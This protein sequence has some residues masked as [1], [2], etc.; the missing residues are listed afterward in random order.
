MKTIQVKPRISHAS[1]KGKAFFIPFNPKINHGCP[2]DHTPPI[3]ST[4]RGCETSTLRDAFIDIINGA[5]H[6]L[7][8]C[9]FLLGGDAVT[10]SLVEAARRLHGHTYVITAL[11][12]KGLRDGID[13][14]GEYDPETVLRGIKRFSALTKAGVYVRGAPDCHAKFLIADNNMALVTSSNFDQNGLGEDK[15][16]AAG[17]AGIIIRGSRALPL[18]EL[19][20][21]VWR[22][23]CSF[24][25]FPH[26][27]PDE[28][29]VTTRKSLTK[30]PPQ[31]PDNPGSVIWTADSCQTI[32]EDLAKHIEHAKQRIFLASYSFTSMQEN[33]KLL[34]E[35]LI[36]AANRGVKIELFLRV[37]T[38]DLSDLSPLLQVGVQVRG[39]LE[40]HAKYVIVD[41][42]F[43]A[44]FTA[45]FDGKHGLT[46]GVEVG[47]RLAKDEFQPLTNY[48][49]KC[50]AAATH[51]VI[52]VNN[53]DQLIKK[54]K[55]VF[56]Y[57]KGQLTVKSDYEDR[58][59]KIM[60]GPWSVVNEGDCQWIC[61]EKD[62]IIIDGSPEKKLTEKPLLLAE[63]VACKYKKYYLG[64]ML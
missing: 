63:A 26:P 12:L 6:Q 64:H 57:T 4:H 62:A 27:N 33:S 28:Y 52:V 56:N 48:H 47:V 16:Y 9:S 15:N 59:Y 19:F 51:C 32:L 2:E 60:D 20:R 43:A 18:V 44:L 5:R 10:Q 30:E 46:S 61:G 11:D 8:C 22:S 45:N 42:D 39:N 21:Y 49:N 31:P 37:R 53:K 38:Q 41:N 24:E 17:E 55:N 14:E 23:K 36:D 54:I 40:N 7:F 34:L 29:A 25:A 13:R 58:V 35:R 1:W 3:L 50:W